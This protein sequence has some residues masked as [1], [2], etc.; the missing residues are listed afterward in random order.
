MGTSVF[1]GGAIQSISEPTQRVDIIPF[2]L[3]T[4]ENIFKKC[5]PLYEKGMSIREIA[6]ETGVPKTTVRETLVEK[7]MA[8]RKFSAGAEELKS[9]PAGRRPGRSQFGY[10]WLQ[11]ELVKDPKE[12][13]IVL[14]IMKLW[15]SGHGIPAI[16]KELNESGV[17]TRSG[18]K[19]Q[20][21]VVADIVKRYKE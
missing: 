13:E 2:Y 10:A 17:S 7:G 3:K 1:Y 18:V 5:A 4:K 21:C 12:Y 16:T 6:R 8:L 15:N 14:R 19:W 11:G 9:K 20:R